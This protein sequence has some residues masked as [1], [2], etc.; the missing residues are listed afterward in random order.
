MK[1]HNPHILEGSLTK[2]VITLSAPIILAM[3]FHS[4]LSIVDTFW[5]GKV[6]FIAVAAVSMAWPIIFI[7]IALAVGVSTGCNALVARYVGAKN[8]NK[9]S[10]VASHSLAIS[11]IFAIVLTIMGIIFSPALF[12]FMG[13]S[14][15]LLQLSVDYTNI[16]FYGSIFTF[17]LFILGAIL[18]G[19]GDSK[20]PMLIGVGINI[21]N[22]VIDPLFIFTFDWG[23]AGAA[24]A[25][26]LS[27]LVGILFYLLYFYQGKSWVK[28]TVRKLKLST[29][30]IYDILAIGLPASLRNIANAIGVFFTI[31]IIAAYGP[32]VIA[33]YGIGWR[34]EGFGVLPIVAIS[35]ATVTIVG[36]NFG[37]NN[38]I[39]AKRSAWVS[40]GISMAIIALFG[41]F[42]FAFAPYVIKIFN[43]DPAVVDIGTAMLKIRVPAFLFAAVIM[44][45]SSAFQA[46]GKSHYSLIL[47]VL[48]VTLMIG[49]AYLFDYYWGFNGV[50]WAVTFSSILMGIAIMVWYQLWQP[51][52]VTEPIES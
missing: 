48:R 43:S 9:S 23:V 29:K 18:R 38:L 47:T 1:N 28:I 27:S 46:F 26:I 13:A 40:S 41:L 44:N 11:I 10:A 5:L 19:E 21:L 16:I 37:A 35:L 50:W 14:G 15:E 2:G 36:Q 24:W 49:L 34:V 20:T 30:I 45:L 22:M 3:F 51:K 32:E 33:A 12:K 31:K 4:L 6:G 39:R 17:N 42:V 25:S 52:S 7:L 8:Q